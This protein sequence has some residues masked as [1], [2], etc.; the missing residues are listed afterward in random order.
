MKTAQDD[1]VT[2][3]IHTVSEYQLCLS[4]KVGHVII[5]YDNEPGMENMRE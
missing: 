4:G 5:D 1:D 3:I 2:L